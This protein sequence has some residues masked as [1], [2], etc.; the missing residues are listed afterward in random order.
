[1][2]KTLRAKDGRTDSKTNGYFLCFDTSGAVSV[3]ETYGRDLSE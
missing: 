1:M 3:W 2:T